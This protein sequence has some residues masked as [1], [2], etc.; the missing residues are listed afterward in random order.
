MDKKYT[1]ENPPKYLSPMP[2][3]AD[4]MAID[5][6]DLVN[7]KF[8]DD[9]EMGV[10]YFKMATINGIDYYSPNDEDW[11]DIIAI[12][13]KNKVAVYTGFFEM[14]DMEAP[15]SGYAKMFHEGTLVCEFETE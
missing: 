14:D 13:H 11:G 12:D 4:G 2:A 10:D 1:R 15:G 6:S 8:A 5:Y 3:A 7:Y 9:L